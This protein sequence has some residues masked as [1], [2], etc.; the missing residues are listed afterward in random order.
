MLAAIEKLVWLLSLSCT[1]LGLL[2][3]TYSGHNPASMLMPE[4]ERMKGCPKIML[5]AWE[6]PEDLSFLKPKQSGVA[7]LANRLVLKGKD[8]TTI[9]RLQVLRCPEGTYMLAVHRIEIDRRQ[10]PALSQSQLDLICRQVLR[11]AALP[12]VFGVQ[13]DF[14]AGPNE[15]KFYRELLLRLR[16][17]LP[18]RSA[19]SMTALASWC[20]GDQWLSKL[21]VDEVVPMLFDMGKDDKQIKQL[22]AKFG[23]LPCADCEKAVGVSTREIYDLSKI[24]GWARQEDILGNRK[25]IYIFSSRAWTK[26]SYHAVL[27]EVEKCR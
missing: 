27:Q 19:L 7:F 3:M 21:P 2:F 16:Q 8:L 14:D 26:E 13:I 9:P 23:K 22:V 20:V 25:R 17:E 11:T 18:K 15:R 12:Y 4:L 6:R 1:S 10:N 24:I 5:W